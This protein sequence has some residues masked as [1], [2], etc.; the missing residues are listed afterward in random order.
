MHHDFFEG[1]EQVEATMAGKKAKLPV[2]YR[3]ARSFTAIFPATVLSLRRL[4]PDSRYVPAQIAPGV[5]AIHL[6]AFEYYDTDIEPYNEFA[7]GVLLNDPQVMPI[8]GYNLLRQL[9]NLTFYT[10]IH[11]LP[12]T[13]E[14]AL[15]GG[16]DVYNYPKFMAEIDFTDT[17]ASVTCELKEKGELILR[18]EGKKVDTPRS[19]VM[20][21]LCHLYQYRQPQGAEFKVNAIR[22]A[23]VPG[24]GKARLEL[25]DR[26]PVA[27]ELR[28]TL[29]STQPFMY[30]Y[31]PEIQC[32]LYGPDRLSLPLLVRLLRE[33]M[34][35]PVERL[36]EE[37]AR[38]VTEER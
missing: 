28:Q 26:H 19:G 18:L 22:Y 34:G 3:S 33:N 31:M 32:I 20:K 1:I 15:R 21:Y 35:I 27:L 25:G 16:I 4:L 10:Y 29:L 7:I 38:M 36:A 17:E 9:L 14:I 24:F 5:G 23:I 11:H 12:V 30:M 13:T 8:P 37:L 6:T 2:F